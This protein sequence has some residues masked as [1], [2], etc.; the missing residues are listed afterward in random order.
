MSEPHIDYPSSRLTSAK[1]VTTAIVAITVITVSA[2]AAAAAV[3]S[4]LLIGLLALT[5]R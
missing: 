5:E 3:P 1:L 2:S 4:V